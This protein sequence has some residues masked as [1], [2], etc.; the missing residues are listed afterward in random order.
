MWARTG[1]VGGV[2]GVEGEGQDVLGVAL[3]PQLGARVSVPQ[4]NVIWGM[5]GQQ[6]VTGRVLVPQPLQVWGRSRGEGGEGGKEGRD[7]Q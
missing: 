3:L 4:N 5:N 6:E 1:H 2:E 7:E